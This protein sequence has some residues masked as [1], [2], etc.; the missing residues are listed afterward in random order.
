MNHMNECI[1]FLFGALELGHLELAVCVVNLVTE[2]SMI[3]P[4]KGFFQHQDLRLPTLTFSFH[5]SKC[6]LAVIW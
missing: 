6:F 1:S 3:H 5:F 4:G 2:S